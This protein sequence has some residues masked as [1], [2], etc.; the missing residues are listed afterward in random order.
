MKITADSVLS[1][2]NL[3][4]G[5]AFEASGRVIKINSGRGGCWC[6]VSL[7]F[8]RSDTM[9]A[10]QSYL[11][12]CIGHLSRPRNSKSKCIGRCPLNPSWC[13]WLRANFFTIH[14]QFHHGGGLLYVIPRS[15]SSWKC[16]S[17]RLWWTWIQ[18]YLLSPL[19]FLPSFWCRWIWHWFLISHLANDYASLK[20][21]FNRPKIQQNRKKW[22]IVCPFKR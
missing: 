10:I 7:V 16:S 1:P 9:A 11:F 8:Y 21:C 5:I 20:D 2:P 17:H 12:L 14:V 6:H 18:S 13:K 22:T 19:E 4:S 15:T 3:V